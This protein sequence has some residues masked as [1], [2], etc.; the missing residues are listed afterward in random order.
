MARND[1]TSAIVDGV[2]KLTV[3]GVTL[4]AGL[5]AP[6]III[7]LEKPL[8]KFLNHMDKRSREREARRIISYMKS[9]G[10]LK[11]EYQHGLKITQKGRRRLATIEFDNLCV[12]SQAQWDHTWRL[13][14]YDIPESSRSGRQALT[15][16][17]RGLGFFQL[18]Q[19][20][21]IHPFPCRETIEKVTS[22]FGLERYVSYIETT[23]LDNETPLLQY[24][25]KRLPN[26]S[27]K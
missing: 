26:V 12:P 11:G 19:S 4:S 5:M 1:T 7:A 2:L 22:N 8:D 15:T 20:V 10:L 27:F 13:V 21:W 25:K 14:F 9:Q 6:N 16:K 17:L 23:H 3:T 24:F 18:Q